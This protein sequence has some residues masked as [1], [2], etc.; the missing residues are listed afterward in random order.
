MDFT[1]QEWLT[2][3]IV[4]LIIGIF[5]DGFRRMRNARRDSLKMS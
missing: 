1:T 4:V 3:L 2:V 5:L